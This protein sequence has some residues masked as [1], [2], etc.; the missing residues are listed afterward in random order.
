SAMVWAPTGL[1]KS[2]FA[3]SVALAVAG[4]GRVLGWSAPKPARVLYVDGEMHIEEVR[5]RM[6]DLIDSG[7]I[8]GL[9]VE[10]ALR[11]LTL[12]C[13]Q[14]QELDVRFWDVMS[15]ADQA[16]LR[17][18]VKDGGYSLV[19]LDNFTVLSDGLTDENSAGA[20]KPALSLLL[21]LKQDDVAAVLIH[22]SG[23][24]GEKFRG[25]SAIAAT[26]EVILGLQPTNDPREDRR[27]SASFT[28][29]VEK[30]RGK[31][32]ETMADR[33]ASLVN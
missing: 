4:G 3:L 19:I 27:Y 21:G 29:G 2:W 17:K 6:R 10:A 1:G 24:S 28:I 9:D 5:D 20:M 33:Q 22:H 25:S 18:M 16:A 13:R 31:R 15:S 26:F 32:D 8:E 23:K 11:N 30:F 12:H 14:H 7:A